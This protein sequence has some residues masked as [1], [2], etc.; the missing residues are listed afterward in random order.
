MS[1]KD[2]I[3]RLSRNL[4]INHQSIPLITNVA[5]RYFRSVLAILRS[6]EFPK[7]SSSSIIPSIP[8]P[9]IARSGINGITNVRRLVI[10]HQ[11][12]RTV[13]IIET[14]TRPKRSI[15]NASIIFLFREEYLEMPKSSHHAP[16]REAL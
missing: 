5:P 2:I 10:P 11:T 13:T 14:T 4:V 3:Y 8:L 1:V 15:V 9:T 6:S 7:N 12:K 16:I